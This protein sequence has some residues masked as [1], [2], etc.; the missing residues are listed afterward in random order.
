MLHTGAAVSYA[1]KSAPTEYG[2]RYSII[3]V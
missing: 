1:P 3:W 2:V